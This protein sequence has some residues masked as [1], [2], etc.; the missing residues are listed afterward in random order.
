MDG[1]KI[2]QRKA[3]YT[4]IVKNKKN[5][6][7]R[8]ASE[9]AGFTC[10]HHG[11][12]NLEGVLV[13]LA[14]DF[15]TS[16]N[17]NFITPI[18]QFGNLLNAS[19]ASGRYISV[20]SNPNFRKWFK[21]E[22]DLIL[23]YEYEDGEKI[24][25]KFYIPIVPTILFNGISGIA[26]GYACKILNYN[27]DDIVA[28]VKLVLANKKQKKMTP[29]YNGYTGT[30]SK[31]NCQTTFIGKFIRNSSTTIK[32]TA[33]PIGHNIESYKVELAKLIDKDEIKDYDDNSTDQGWEI[34][35]YASRAWIA[36]D[37]DTLLDK[38]KLVT[39][40]SENITV[41]TENNKIKYFEQPEELIEHFV[42]VRLAK[43]EDRRLK[44][45]D[46]LAEEYAWAEEK[47]RFIKFFLKNTKWFSET[48]KADIILRLE[49]E[50]FVNITDLL[51]IRIYNLQFE[52]IQ[53]LENEIVKIEAKIVELDKMSAQKMYLH[54]LK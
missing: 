32:I 36:Q 43:Y 37:D 51:S 50:K 45:L 38:L 49:K 52:E 8:Y 2:S 20:E 25:P 26:T 31:E 5:T 22:D 28:N 6:V 15:P 48:K 53:D 23:E 18:G 4:L 33:L 11:S 54:D 21:K 42:A 44:Q 1:F 35:I 7:E 16:N 9:I 13:G 24:E 34:L 17:V 14:Q 3:I 40:E 12:V 46:I 39:R 19:A 41:W 10:F 30:V 47:I 27:P 29:W